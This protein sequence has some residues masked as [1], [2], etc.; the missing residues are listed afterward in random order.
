MFHFSIVIDCFR[1]ALAHAILKEIRGLCHRMTGTLQSD[2]LGTI[3]GIPIN[4]FQN[5]PFVFPELSHTHVSKRAVSEG[6]RREENASSP[7]LCVDS[8]TFR[9]VF[10]VCH[11][12]VFVTRALR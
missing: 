1:Q 6:R 5:R 2:L 9:F 8:K 7:P 12:A 4:D 3:T 11:N 10:P